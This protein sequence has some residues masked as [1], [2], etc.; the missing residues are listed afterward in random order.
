[1]FYKRFQ[2]STSTRLNWKFSNFFFFGFH[3]SFCR[4]GS[5]SNRRLSFLS[6]SNGEKLVRGRNERKQHHNIVCRIEPMQ[7]CP[8]GHVYVVKHQDRNQTRPCHKSTNQPSRK[9]L[10]SFSR[11]NKKKASI[12]FFAFSAPL[13]HDRFSIIDLPGLSAYKKAKS[14]STQTITSSRNVGNRRNG[15]SRVDRRERLGGAAV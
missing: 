7:A 8:D 11:I 4:S 15:P 2:T 1:M 9:N 6:T 13:S 5:S 12:I 3:C 14:Q 10:N